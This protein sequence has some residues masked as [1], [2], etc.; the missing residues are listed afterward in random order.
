MNINI[1]NNFNA[2][3]INI[4]ILPKDNPKK[5]PPR[6]TTDKSIYRQCLK[7]KKP[8]DQINTKREL[9]S[10]SKPPVSFI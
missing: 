6:T 4:N 1:N 5:E 10:N 2:N 8:S 7:S 9:S 3:S